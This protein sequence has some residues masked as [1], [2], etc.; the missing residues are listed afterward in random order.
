M[1]AETI[2]NSENTVFIL[3]GFLSNDI[4][5]NTLLN[6]NHRII[7]TIQNFIRI[8]ILDQKP[9]SV[10]LNPSVSLR[11]IKN[12]IIQFDVALFQTVILKISVNIKK[13]FAKKLSFSPSS[14][15][16]NT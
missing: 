3:N 5:G 1:Q 12:L 6:K 10:K 11:G 13:L 16:C 15:S 2:Y 7:K 14:R 8:K 9:L 4:R